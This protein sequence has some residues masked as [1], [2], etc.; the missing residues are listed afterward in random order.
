MR[1]GKCADPV[2]GWAGGHVEQTIA[3]VPFVKNDSM[4]GHGRVGFRQRRLPGAWPAASGSQNI[5][6]AEFQQAIW[7][8]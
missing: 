2:G 6:Q 4:R 5:L 3:A 8:T 7:I 1:A